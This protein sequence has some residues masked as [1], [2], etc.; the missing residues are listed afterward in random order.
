MSF[1]TIRFS[2][3]CGCISLLFSVNSETLND[4][5][6]KTVETKYGAVRG[7]VKKTLLHQKTYYSFRG[8][9]FAKPPV[10]ELRFKAPGVAE[11]W[12]PKTLDAFEYGKACSQLHFQLFHLESSEDCL[13][14][15]VFV[16]GE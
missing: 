4:L 10:D 14:I 13:F 1:K 5:F 16:P 2:L 3:I 15:N 12:S 6:Y 11:P 9:P 7:L 8:I